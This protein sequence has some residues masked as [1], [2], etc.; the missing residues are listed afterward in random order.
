MS[1]RRAFLKQGGAGLVGAA[2]MEWAGSTFAAGASQTL[3]VGAIGC[4]GRGTSVAREFAGVKGVEVA[5]VCDPDAARAGSAAKA[6][7]KAS[8]T[9]P[10]VVGD[11]RRVL[12]D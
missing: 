7:A 2:A 11:L 5:Y 8:G 3:V 4:G 1:N 10:K 12:D 9:T 6:I